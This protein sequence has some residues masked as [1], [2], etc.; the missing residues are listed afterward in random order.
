MSTLFHRTGLAVVGMAVVGLAAAAVVLHGA[1]AQAAPV[2]ATVDT[3]VLAG[4]SDAGIERFKGI[5]YA[6]APVGPLR[7]RPPQAPQAWSGD[8]AATDFGA[9]C[10]QPDPGANIS[11]DSAGARASEDCLFLN[12]WAPAKPGEAAH[13]VM[14]WLHGGGNREGSGAD[15]FFD[16]TAFA[17]DGVVLVTI[18]YRLG[19]FGFFAH[20][21]LTAEATA[22]QPLGDYGL[23]DQMAAL[24]WVKRNI[25]AFGGDPANVTVFGESAGGKDVMTLL[26]TPAAKG[27]FDK[28]IVESGGT[29]SDLLDLTQSETLG[30]GLVAAARLPGAQATAAQLRA[31][32]TATVAAL[33]EQVQAS[34]PLVDGRLVPRQPNQTYAMGGAIDVPLIIGTN[35]EES[36]LLGDTAPNPA[37]MFPPISGDLPTLRAGYGP[38]AEGDTRFAH[39][40]FQDGLFAAP[41]RWVAAQE[42]GGQP[43]W[44]YRFTYVLHVIEDR[45]GPEHASEIPYVFDTWPTDTPM[46]DQDRNMVR[47]LHGCWV[48]FAKTGAP[49]CPGLPD[50]PA[51]QASV[52]QLMLFAPNL[53][54]MRNVEDAPELD[55]LTARLIEQK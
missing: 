34:G 8:R 7:W 13:P 2:K 5:P 42:S 4:T 29:W 43:S 21:A 14:V 11:R 52:D 48:A 53:I 17:R 6:T 47:A 45:R 32:P 27:L 49:K 31:M 54:R 3:G 23:M 41:A 24:A 44:L 33:S 10:V 28:A 15:S 36:S 37:R 18:N 19:L 12:I 9:S 51:Y 40:L 26:A 20:P 25:A 38:K 46:T 30:A 55:I 16:G 1:P 50:W 39:A 22:D 35:G